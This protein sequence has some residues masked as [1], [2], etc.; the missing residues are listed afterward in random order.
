MVLVTAIMNVASPFLE[1]AVRLNVLQSWMLAFY[2]LTAAVYLH[3]PHLYM[4]FLATLFFKGLLA[5]YLLMKTLR[6]L[7]E[8]REMDM[9]LSIPA[10]TVFSGL[11][12]V[13]AAML[14]AK[15]LNFQSIFG[16]FALVSSISTFLIGAM[17]IVVRKILLSQILGLLIMENAIF[18]AANSVTKGMPLIVELG[19][20]FDILVSVLITSLLLLRIKRS[21]EEIKIDR[22]EALKE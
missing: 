20:L 13:I 12:V 16:K 4:S 11:L 15:L 10:A 1:F 18:L 5:P 6:R 3:T 7:G 14:S 17:L 21:F 9:F 2:I 19:V 8:E 22:L